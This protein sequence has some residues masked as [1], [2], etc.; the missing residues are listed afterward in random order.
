M[1]GIMK[2]NTVKPVLRG[3]P[4]DKEKMVL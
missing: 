4:Y 3:H 2:Y 1:Q